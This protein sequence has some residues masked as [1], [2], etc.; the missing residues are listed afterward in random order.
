MRLFRLVLIVILLVVLGVAIQQSLLWLGVLGNG[1]DSQVKPL[2]DGDQEIAF[3]EPATSIDDWGRIVTAIEQL[4]K[5]WPRINPKL[6]LL[7]VSMKDAFPP[8]SADVPEIVFTLGERRGSKLRLRWYKISG[9]HDAESWV[10]K[11]HA[12]GRQPL[13]IIG[14]GTSDRAIKLAARLRDT[15]PDPTVPS[16]I[17]LMTTATAEET[18]TKRL[19]V[20][21]LYKDR[22]FRFSFTNRKMVDSLLQFAQ[23]RE[24]D[25]HAK[26]WGAGNLWPHEPTKQP[27]AMHAVAWQDERYSLDM[28]EMFKK[29]FEKEFPQGS[30]H[31]VASIHGSIGG[32]NQPAPPEQVVVGMFLARPKPVT[33][34]SFLVLPTQ[35]VRMRRFLI[36]LHGRSASVARNLVVLNGDAI[37]LNAVY[38]DRDVIWNI[39]DLPFSLVFFAHRNPIDHDADFP[40]ITEEGDVIGQGNTTATNDVLLFRD[41][42]EAILYAAYD[43]ARLLNDPFTVRDRLRESCWHS[44]EPGSKEAPH[45]CHPRVHELGAKPQ[46]L[47]DDAGD[48]QIRTGEHIVW[49]KPF[50]TEQGVDLKSMISVWTLPPAAR[51]EEG[52]PAAAPGGWRLVEAFPAFYNQSRGEGAQP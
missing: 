3:I 24:F 2:S 19:S 43:D 26:Q 38:R 9:E 5:D 39:L 27:Y 28:Y 34:N 51:A 33:P 14:G 35:S 48:R 23:H 45:V 18:K 29:E 37:S 7:T 25:D 4:Q 21:N 8:L 22:T 11:L 47:F 32:F 41:V 44:P 52:R 42:F 15:Y 13:A 20:I 6:P 49:L 30:F 36:N 12:R 50:F 31:E 46:R 40:T 1:G 10:K 16:P 17:L